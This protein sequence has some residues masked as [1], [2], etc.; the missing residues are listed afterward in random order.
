MTNNPEREKKWNFRLFM[1]EWFNVNWLLV[2]RRRSLLIGWKNKAIETYSPQKAFMRVD[3]LGITFFSKLLCCNNFLQLDYL[4]NEKNW[5]SIGS[6]FL[7][8]WPKK[9]IFINLFAVGEKSHKTK[10]T[11]KINTKNHHFTN[12]VGI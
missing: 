3:F 5:T 6:I 9:E 12:N 8:Y 2:E 11:L 10:I 1:F 7:L 4:V